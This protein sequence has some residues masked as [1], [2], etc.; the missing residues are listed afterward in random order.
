VQSLRDLSNIARRF[1]KKRGGGDSVSLEPEAKLTTPKPKNW[2]FISQP[3]SKPFKPDVVKSK[4]DG[5]M[6]QAVQAEFNTIAGT[7]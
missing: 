5:K 4:W 3:S 2:K 1:G 7:M 6:E